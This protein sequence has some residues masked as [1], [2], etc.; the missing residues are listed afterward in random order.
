MLALKAFTKLSAL[1][2]PSIQSLIKQASS[3]GA[4]FKLSFKNYTVLIGQ[5]D[6]KYDDIEY[7][8]LP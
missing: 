7:D 3:V 2:N 4:G 8:A 6:S 5:P 1:T